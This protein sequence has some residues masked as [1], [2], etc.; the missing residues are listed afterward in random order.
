MCGEHCYNVHRLVVSVQSG[1]F[2]R[3]CEGGF[4]EAT[5][6]KVTLHEDPPYAVKLMVDWFYNFDYIDVPNS[7]ETT[8][9][10]VEKWA[11]EVHST[12][13]TLADKYDIPNLKAY[14]LARAQRVST[15][16]CADKWLARRSQNMLAGTLHAFQN[17]PPTDDRLCK[18]LLAGWVAN[19]KRLLRHTDKEALES[20]MAE[21]PN[22]ASALVAELG[23]FALKTKGEGEIQVESGARYVMASTHP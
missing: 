14:A 21:T 11:L 3:L 6:R 13:F 12:M 4:K 10:G 22:F 5:E 2:K 8:D 16:C 15:R 7:A 20:A 17:A 19:D 18:A 1:Y 23:G 9:S